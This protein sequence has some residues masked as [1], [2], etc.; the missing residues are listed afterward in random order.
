VVVVAVVAVVVHLQEVAVGGVEVAVVVDAF[1]RACVGGW[2]AG[3]FVQGAFIVVGCMCV[4]EDVCEC[5]VR[6]HAR[7]HACMHACVREC[8]RLFALVLPRCS[9]SGPATRRCF[10]PTRHHKQSTQQSAK[11]CRCQTR[12]RALLS[13]HRHLPLQGQF[14]FIVLDN[15]KRQAF[16]ARD[17]SGAET[18]FYRIGDDGE[19]LWHLATPVPQPTVVCL[20]GTARIQ[21]ISVGRSRIGLC[22]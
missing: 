17:P 5:G 3:V 13:S 1:E 2:T 9:V 4:R 15:A 22:A 8:I 19:R 11:Q 21:C 12:C 10:K 16:A 7:T 20:Q 18:L 6:V 14:A